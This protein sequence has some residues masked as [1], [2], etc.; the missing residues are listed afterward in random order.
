LLT[1]PVGKSKIMQSLRELRLE[2]K[3]SPEC[4]NSI[5]RSMGV[6]QQDAKR[7]VK[8]RYRWDEFYRALNDL[9]G[10]C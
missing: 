4:L 9:K 10:G 2:S 7:I 8:L 3:G 1:I 6:H 5:S